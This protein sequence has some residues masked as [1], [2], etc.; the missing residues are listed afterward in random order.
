MDAETVAVMATPPGAGGIAL[1]QV[2]GPSARE[3]AERA[4]VRLKP[5]PAF[6]RVGDDV[7]ARFLRPVRSPWGMPTV[8]ISC[9]GG[10]AAPQAVLARLGVRVVSREELYDALVRGRKL[11]RTRA[12]ARLLLASAVTERAAAMLL[13]Q[14]GG[15]LAKAVR[16]MRTGADARR[17]LAS[18]NAGRALVTPPKVVIAGR[19]NAGK[20]T[21]LNALARRDRALVSVIPGT[22]RDPVEETVAFDGWP[23]RLVDT[24]GFL[25]RFAEGPGAAIEREAVAR[26]GEAAEQAALTLWMRDAREPPVAGPQA[27]RPV[28]RV[29][30]KMD[31]PES[32]AVRAEI[33]ISAKT[34]AGLDRL[35]RSVLRALEL[36]PV[37]GPCVFTER[38]ELLLRAAAAGASLS[39]VKERLLWT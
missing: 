10:R 37:K 17:L 38:Q 3:V 12:E 29:A 6:S 23:F 11:D 18:A 35:R 34:G 22:T 19:P 14:A 28:L 27:G 7:L 2:V 31:L 25:D 32:Q 39:E 33:S 8:E 16:G 13:E 1:L 9:H 5:A 36:R 24:A 30:N 20:S 15:A 26:S 4:G 21:L